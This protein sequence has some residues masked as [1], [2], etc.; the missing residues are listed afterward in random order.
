MQCSKALSVISSTD[1]ERTIRVHYSARGSK[2]FFVL[3]IWHSGQKGL[4]NF[5]K[6]VG[7]KFQAFTIAKRNQKDYLLSSYSLTEFVNKGLKKCQRSA[8]LAFFQY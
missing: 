4:S 5:G 6:L 1:W 7:L 3:F 2:I 8:L